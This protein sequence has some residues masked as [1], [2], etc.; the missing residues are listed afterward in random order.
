M[1]KWIKSEETNLKIKIDLIIICNRCSFLFFFFLN[2]LLKSYFCTQ[3]SATV[4]YCDIE[5]RYWRIIKEKREWESESFLYF[6]IFPQNKTF[7]YFSSSRLVSPRL[8]YICGAKD[9]DD[10]RKGEKKKERVREVNTKKEKKIKFLLKLW[11][12][13]SSSNTNNNGCLD[14]AKA[15]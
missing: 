8:A 15:T 2:R 12:L 9:H 3:I 7:F 14:E 11:P 13:C 1:K 6:K 4:K 5:K 10:K